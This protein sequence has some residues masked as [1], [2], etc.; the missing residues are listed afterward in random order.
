MPRAQPGRSDPLPGRSSARF[1]QRLERRRGGRGRGGDAAVVA[2][3]SQLDGLVTPALIVDRGRLVA[4]ISDMAA[5]ASA[6]GV[7]L[8][9]HAKTHKSPAIAALQREHGAAGLTVATLT[10]AEG[11]AD[12]GV[13]DLL[14]TAPPVGDW[15]LDRLV[16]L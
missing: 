3:A 15:R 1:P 2:A 8:R 11:F 13:D 7:A 6:L 10:E 16:A 5:R 12:E 14:L 9:P 4:N